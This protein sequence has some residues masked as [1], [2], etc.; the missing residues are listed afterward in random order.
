MGE[1]EKLNSLYTVKKGGIEDL[2][3]SGNNPI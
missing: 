1:K 2:K 3:V